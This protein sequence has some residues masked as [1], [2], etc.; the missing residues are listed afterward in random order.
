MQEIQDDL[1]SLGVTMVA[2]SPQSEE[3]NKR[4]IEAH[5]LTFDI[6]WDQNNN[7]TRKFGI[8]FSFPDYLVEVYKEM[9]NNFPETNQ[10][11]AWELP[12]PARYIIDQEG[13]IRY[14]EVN[15]DYKDRP[16]PGHTV[17]ALKAI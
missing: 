12:M 17:A 11:D 13:I 7:V 4:M 16:E 8:T 5:G 15:P 1:K 6:L 10:H 14:A 9:G 3:T 2:I